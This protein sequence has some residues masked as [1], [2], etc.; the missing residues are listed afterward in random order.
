MATKKAATT[1][2]STSSRTTAAKKTTP[3]K[4]TKTSAAKA[5][6]KKTE[7]VAAKTKAV[8][9]WPPLNIGGIIL[10]ELVG[11]FVLTM[12]AL[13]TAS[14]GVWYVGVTLVVLILA[15]GAVSGVHIN[16]AVSLAL[17]TVRKINWKDLLVYWGSQIVG[18]MLA[19][20]LMY[21]FTNGHFT[22]G[23]GNIGSFDWSV[24]GVELV[25]TAIFLFGIVSVLGREEISNGVKAV[26]IG[27]SLTIALV[28]G[29]ALLDQVKSADYAK[30]QKD[31]S[32]V[33][34]SDDAAASAKVPRS[35]YIKGVVANPAVALASTEST[36]AQLYGTAANDETAKT[37]FTL[38]L[39]AGTLVGG[40]LGAQLARLVAYRP[41][42]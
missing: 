23:F 35:L 13:T 11:T 20:V 18:A 12:V 30:Y 42:N 24:F 29:G 1:K 22:M 7:S 15:L 34:S 6:T 5:D 3:K 38:D 28:A 27:L 32:A 17:W 21:L 39:I 4:T 8:K 25:A 37:R 40:I 14:F 36:E 31:A 41:K 26:G 19:V 9:A 10:A 33:S 16:P 2:K